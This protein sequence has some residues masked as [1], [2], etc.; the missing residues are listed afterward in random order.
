MN[1]SVGTVHQGDCTNRGFDQIYSSY[2]YFFLFLWSVDLF[3]MSFSASTALPVG[4]PSGDPAGCRWAARGG[5]SGDTRVLAAAPLGRGCL[6]FHNGRVCSS[7]WLISLLAVSWSRA[8]A[9]K[10]PRAKLSLRGHRAKNVCWTPGPRTRSHSGS[11]SGSHHG[12]PNGDR[13]VQP[14]DRVWLRA[15]P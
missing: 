11:H 1:S 3:S 8:S 10:R 6:A 5:G 4:G 15:E 14:G 13:P 2:I 12:W 9:Y 7:I